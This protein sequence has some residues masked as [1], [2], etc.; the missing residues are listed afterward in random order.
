[1][2][3]DRRDIPAQEDVRGK[4]ARSKSDTNEDG[5]RTVA[6]WNANRSRQGERRCALVHFHREYLI[7]FRKAAL[8]VGGGC[9]FLP[10]LVMLD[11][12]GNLGAPTPPIAEPGDRAPPI[13][14]L[15][16]VRQ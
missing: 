6:F 16:R 12:G 3:L 13:R 9:G 14:P 4:A 5:K 11:L 2:K 15:K 10:Q 7:C 8:K 1:M